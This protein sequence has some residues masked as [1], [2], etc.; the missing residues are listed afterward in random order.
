MNMFSLVTQIMR[1]Q[2]IIR[3]H[4]AVGQIF[5]ITL[6]CIGALIGGFPSEAQAIDVNLF[7]V[8]PGT[9]R[10]LTTDLGTIG[11]HLEIAPQVVTQYAYRPVGQ[12]V[13]TND[14]LIT[15]LDHRL[16][17]DLGF[18]LSL[19]RRFQIAFNLP[20][21]LYQR[22]NLNA[23]PNDIVYFPEPYGPTGLEDL[24]FYVKGV[25]LDSD[26]LSSW[27]NKNFSF[28]LGLVG[29][30][31][32][33]TST[34]FNA[35]SSLPTLGL[36]FVGHLRY[37]RFLFALN[38]GALIEATEHLGNYQTGPGILYGVGIQVETFRKSQGALFVLA[39]VNGKSHAPFDDSHNSPAEFLLALKGSYQKWNFFLGGGTGLDRGYGAPVARVF[40]GATFAFVPTA[41]KVATSTATSI[42]LES[43]PP[44][45]PEI[46]IRG[47]KI[48][49]NQKTF[50]DFGQDSIRAEDYPILD[51]LAALLISRPD[52]QL[53]RI[54]GH[55]D[56]QGSAYFNQVLSLRRATTVRA[57]LVS[58]GIDPKRLIAE[59]FGLDCP[60]T[61]NDTDENRAKNRRVEFVIVQQEGHPLNA[62]RCIENRK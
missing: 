36:K 22:L 27:K 31:S 9:G 45:K 32:L 59:G 47:R 56:D 62:M 19:F 20:I 37:Q 29:D 6:I 48:E 28:G 34:S 60:I 33:P 2:P 25:F 7:H 44:L 38:F 41:K 58:K 55:T 61:P 30:L 1:Q 17:L 52:I 10:I 39:E 11:P 42:P 51:Q 21:T 40:V 3:K 50:L 18:S 13:N 43:S 5:S 15:A 46:E 24:H 53:V 23:N 12:Y 57:Y 49:I 16:T 14:S 35:G 26:L 8:A 4:R 54:E